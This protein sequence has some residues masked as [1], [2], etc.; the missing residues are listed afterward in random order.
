M[1]LFWE[2]C[3]L[4]EDYVIFYV[5]FVIF[6]LSYASFYLRHFKAKCDHHRPVFEG[7]YSISFQN[8][9][10]H[11]SLPAGTDTIPIP[12]PYGSGAG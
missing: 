11:D 10:F 4:Q 1:L 8:L 9:V 12:Q 6:R 2:F 7:I 3:W 5:V